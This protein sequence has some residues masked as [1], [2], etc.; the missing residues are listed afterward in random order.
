M[1][2]FNH[3]RG[4]QPIKF[5]SWDA[6]QKT[7]P[8]FA[9][10]GMML[11]MMNPMGSMPV[12]MMTMMIYIYN[13]GVCVCM[14]VTFLLI[15]PSPCQADDIYIMMECVCV[16][17]FVTPARLSTSTCSLSLV[18]ARAALHNTFDYKPIHFQ[19][20]IMIRIVKRMMIDWELPIYIASEPNWAPEARSEA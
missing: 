2:F 13:D 18:R 3:F 7:L 20:I 6:L 14:C 5:Q 9:M 16:C 4:F 8:L 10:A 12:A 15:L 19:H 17:M 1:A 11:K